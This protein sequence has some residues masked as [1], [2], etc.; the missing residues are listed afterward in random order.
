[1][2]RILVDSSLICENLCQLAVWRVALGACGVAGSCH[3]IC[4]LPPHGG[5][6]Y[7]HDKKDNIEIKER[8]NMSTKIK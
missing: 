4:V 1:M 2:L 6:R 7:T 3:Q 5:K 8:K